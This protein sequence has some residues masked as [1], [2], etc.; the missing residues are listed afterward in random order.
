MQKYVSVL[1]LMLSLSA[2]G[3]TFVPISIK[4]Q[5]KESDAIVYG[6]VINSESIPDAGGVV[7]RVFI[8]TDKWL[9]LEVSNN[10]I[11]VLYPGGTLENIATSVAGTPTFREGEQVVIFLSQ[12]KKGRYWG[13]NLGLG[14]YSEKNFGD[15]KILVNE[16]FPSHPKM[17]QIPSRYFFNL[18]PKLKAKEFTVRSKDKYEIQELRSR[19]RIKAEKKY[20]RS[21]AG[22]SNRKEEESRNTISI[23]WLLVIL[24]LMGGFSVLKNKRNS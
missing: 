6:K 17:G 5:V 4:K 22:V 14:K 15:G 23:F 9:G 7:T 19:S 16:I 1:C 18:V 11:E 24:G 13:R 10:H 12:D 21:V 20:G 2:I 8:R 3:S